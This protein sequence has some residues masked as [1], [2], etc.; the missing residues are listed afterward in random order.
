MLQTGPSEKINY[1]G[2]L[3]YINDKLV[4]HY[5]EQGRILYNAEMPTTDGIVTNDFAEYHISDHL[6]NVRVRYV[7]KDDN[8]TL[9]TTKVED[10]TEIV[11]SYHYYPFGML[12]EGNFSTHQSVQNRYQSLMISFIY[13]IKK[14]LRIQE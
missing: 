1:D 10:E 8:G 2:E 5:H 4:S 14:V 12:M 6:G 11:G 13:S 7:D 3:E 9:K